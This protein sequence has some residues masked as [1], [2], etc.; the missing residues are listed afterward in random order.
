MSHS[1]RH[2]A[3]YCGHLVQLAQSADVFAQVA[4]KGYEGKPYHPPPLPPLPAFRVNKA[5]QFA[6]TVVDYAGPLTRSIR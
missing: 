1:H 3:Q 5:P 2:V 6:Y 4:N